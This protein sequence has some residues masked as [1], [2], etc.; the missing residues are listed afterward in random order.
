[1]SATVGKIMASIP[2]DV[3]TDTE[4]TQ[5]ITGTPARRHGLVKRALARGDFV[6]VKRGLY[7][8]PESLRSG[9]LD[10]RVLAQYVYGPSCVSLESALSHH[11][12][13]PEAVYAT[14]SVTSKRSRNFQTRFGL[15]TYHRVPCR[16]FLAGVERIEDRG[17]PILMATPWRAVADLVYVNRRD[18]KGTEPLVQS[19]RID[20]DLLKPPPR[21]QIDELCAAY[22]SRR[23]R[24]F[25]ESI[26]EESGP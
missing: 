4:L 26:A 18:W 5:L 3:F 16:P 11:G 1:L 23:V 2:R 7:C 9:S 8:R 17:G 22:R 20:S 13:I 14:T 19:L 10:L 15:F 24:S 12:W 25:L 6:R 21:E